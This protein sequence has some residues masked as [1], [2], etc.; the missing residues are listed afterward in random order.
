MIRLGKAEAMAVDKLRGYDIHVQKSD[1]RLSRAIVDDDGMAR[2][3][4][5]RL[6]Y[7]GQ[8]TADLRLDAITTDNT[9]VW[10]DYIRSQAVD[11]IVNSERALNGRP[12]IDT[13]E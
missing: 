13:D 1:G 9:S 12:Y 8:F 10:G 5:M 3:Y 6:L 2:A 11:L 7:R 4:G